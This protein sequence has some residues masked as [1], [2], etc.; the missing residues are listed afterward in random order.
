MLACG[1]DVG[2]IQTKTVIIDGNRIV[3]GR[4]L[5]HS[6]ANLARSARHALYEALREAD[7]AEY[8][9][10]Y[11]MGTGYGRHSIPFAQA[12]TAEPAC[13]GKGA[14]YRFPGTRT[15]LDIG[16]Q[17]TTAIKIDENGNVLDFAT[18]DKCA[19]GTGRFL[20]AAAELLNV[21]IEKMSELGLSS[22]N[23]LH[24]AN[25]CSVLAEAEIISYLEQKK[26]VEEIM[27]GVF[28]G[29][30][31]RAVGL[32]SRIGIEEEITLTGGV[33][34]NRAMVRAIE[35]NLHRPVNVG[36]DTVYMG[37]L[38]AALLGLEKAG[39]SDR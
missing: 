23:T 3:Q 4:G 33:G 13:H 20:E 37:A 39:S 32:L 31:N 8:D 16:G 15:I 1:I 9:I 18:N 24:F 21:S 12:V 34:Q 17:D 36:V 6:G 22:A 30:A 2:S 7:V 19:A 25:I 5:V 14:I 27:A 35:E 29:L 28:Q 26:P 10:T 11:V 38:G